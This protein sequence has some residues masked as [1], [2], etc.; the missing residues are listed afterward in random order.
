MDIDTLAKE[1]GM[2]SFTKSVFRWLFNKPISYRL[3]DAE[4]EMIRKEYANTYPNDL[5]RSMSSIA[6]GCVLEKIFGKD[7]FENNNS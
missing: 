4:K 1:F 6:I 5:D 3:T 2:S 7:F